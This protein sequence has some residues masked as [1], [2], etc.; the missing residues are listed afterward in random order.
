MCSRRLSVQRPA[1]A[2]SAAKGAQKRKNKV[3]ALWKNSTATGNAT[4]RG[5]LQRCQRLIRT[6]CAIAAHASEKDGIR[7]IG[8]RASARAPDHKAGACA[9]GRLPSRPRSRGEKKVGAKEERWGKSGNRQTLQERRERIR[10]SLKSGRGGGGE[11][12]S[13]NLGNL[14]LHRSAEKRCL[15]LRPGKPGDESARAGKTFFFSANFFFLFCLS[16]K[17]KPRKLFSSIRYA[18]AV[19]L[20]LSR[21]D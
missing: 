20:S 3:R 12:A 15:E 14:A 7:R 19:R 18:G 5:S 17:P 21:L 13:S 6:L 10:E 8:N 9:V 2:S 11:I 1:S 4:V 16:N